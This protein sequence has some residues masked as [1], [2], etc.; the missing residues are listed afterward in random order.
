MVMVRRPSKRNAAVLII[1][2][3]LFLGPYTSASRSFIDSVGIT[4]IISI[5]R[6]PTCPDHPNVQY[7]R[8]QLFGQGYV[9]Y[10]RG[11]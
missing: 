8:L 3:Y 4:H 6:T 9:L 5:G 10:L 11:Q 1:P 7:H 2:P